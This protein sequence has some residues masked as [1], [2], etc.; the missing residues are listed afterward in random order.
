L[1]PASRP[2]PRIGVERVGL[3]AADDE[4]AAAVERALR[5]IGAAGWQLVDVGW[6]DRAEVLDLST[7]IMF[8][9]AAAVHRTLLDSPEAAL[10]GAPVAERFHTGATIPEPDYRAALAAAERLGA[11]VR[12]VLAAVDAVV[13]PTVPL[14]AP[15][16]EAARQDPTLP[17]RIVAETRLANVARTPALTV[18]VPPA[19]P[20]DLPVGLQLTAATD[21]ATLAAGEAVAALLAA[22]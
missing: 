2:A 18:P 10:L 3:E 1:A 21:A 7:T 12:G 22:G 13:G 20:G 15:T 11:Q 8:A 9:E 5:A 6:P 4:V 16:V 19:S 14:V 17:R